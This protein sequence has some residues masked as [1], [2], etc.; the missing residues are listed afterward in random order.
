MVYDISK[1]RGANKLFS[2]CVYYNKISLAMHKKL[3]FEK[4]GFIKSIGKED[5][6]EIFF[7]KKIQK[8][9]P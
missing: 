8:P 3:G 1:N 9:N 7:S 6:R 2:S 5:E 4:C